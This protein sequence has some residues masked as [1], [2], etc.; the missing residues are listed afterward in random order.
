MVSNSKVALAFGLVSGSYE[1]SY[2]TSVV[3]VIL[4]RFS[5]DELT[6]WSPSWLHT[7]T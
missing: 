7:I 1:S 6:E 5:S 3:T 4:R 2:I